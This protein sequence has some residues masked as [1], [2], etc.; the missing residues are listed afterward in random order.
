[1]EDCIFCRIIKNEIPS[2]KVHETP[3]IVAFRDI[4]PVSPTHILILPKKHIPSVSE[5]S[6][7]DQSLLG[8]LILTAKALASE[9][10][11]EDYRLV[12]NNGEGAGQT[13]FHLHVHLLSGRFFS[14]PPG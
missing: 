2:Q 12:I 5:S 7:V 13:V 14:W 4:H 10:G 11:L 3:T 9:N 8:E 6:A 1:M